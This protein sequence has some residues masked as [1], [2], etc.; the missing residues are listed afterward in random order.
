MT[1]THSARATSGRLRRVFTSALL[2]LSV[3]VGTLAAT[4]TPANAASSV[5]GCFRSSQGWDLWG[6]HASLAV[7]L[8]GLGWRTVASSP[9]GPNNFGSGNC[10][11]WGPMTPDLQGYHWKVFVDYQ[12]NGVRFIGKLQPY[13]YPG[14]QPARLGTGVVT[15][16]GC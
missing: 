16:Y 15:C 3:V 7:W 13:A 11:F 1:N 14:D 4:A 12:A 10:V 5:H 8:P 9:L 6:V 2:A